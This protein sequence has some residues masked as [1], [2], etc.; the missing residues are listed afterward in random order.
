M[1]DAVSCMRMFSR[2][3]LIRT[4]IMFSLK[5]R[6]I[7]M[8][9]FTTWYLGFWHLIGRSGVFIVCCRVRRTIFPNFHYFHLSLCRLD[10]SASIDGK[11]ELDLKYTSRGLHTD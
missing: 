7:R 2:A 6:D 8:G 9:F 4:I 3:C 11:C 10:L 1:F 5:V